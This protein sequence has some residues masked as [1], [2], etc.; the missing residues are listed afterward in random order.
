VR[1]PTARPHRT[2]S[3]RPRS[4]MASQHLSWGSRL[5]TRLTSLFTSSR[6]FGLSTFYHPA[7]DRVFEKRAKTSPVAR[8]NT[9]E[10]KRRAVSTAAPTGPDPD[11]AGA[12]AATSRVVSP[13]VR[14]SQEE[15]RQ[16]VENFA[17][18][19]RILWEWESQE[20]TEAA[21]QPL[22]SRGGLGG[23]GRAEVE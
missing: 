23:K 16:A 15:L 22:V 19:L 5:R 7:M 13:P 8:L 18:F 3:T 2:S 10:S 6:S 1:D 9:R 12:A 11:E 21:G 20:K 14:W 17:A 4:I